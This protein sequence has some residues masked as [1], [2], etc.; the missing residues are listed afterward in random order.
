MRSGRTPLQVWKEHNTAETLISESSAQTDRVYCHKYPICVTLS[1]NQTIQMCLVQIRFQLQNESI[2]FEPKESVVRSLHCF[3]VVRLWLKNGAEVSRHMDSFGQNKAAVW[4]K[5]KFTSNQALI[6]PQW[7]FL[8]KVPRSTK[9]ELKKKKRMQKKNH[10]ESSRGRAFLPTSKHSILLCAL[11]KTQ[12]NNNMGRVFHAVCGDLFTEHL[13][14]KIKSINSFWGKLRA[15]AKLPVS[16][17]FKPNDRN[18]LERLLR[19]STTSCKFF[20]WK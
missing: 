8:I 18:W 15:L 9:V 11:H 20:G 1:L 3:H 10:N 2:A 6:K 14:S 19:I 7:E 12:L 13:D 17:A 16:P 5:G 4:E